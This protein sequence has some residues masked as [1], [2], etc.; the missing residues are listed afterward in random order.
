MINDCFYFVLSRIRGLCEANKK[1]F[2]D[3]IFYPIGNG[4]YWS[5]FRK[6][7]FYPAM[8]QTERS[9]SVSEHECY[10]YRRNRWTYKSVMLSELGRQLVG[11]IMKAMEVNL[12]KAVKFKYKL[13]ANPDMLDIETQKEF[14][15]MGISLP[16]VIRDSVAEYYVQ[17]TRKEVLV[18]PENLEKIRKEALNIQ[19]KLIV[20]ED[21]EETS[22]V[23][24]EVI[25]AVQSVSDVWEKFRAALS[26]T[27]LDAL[28]IVLQERS[29][30]TFASEN[31]IM[32]EVLIDGINQKAVDCIG[33]TVMEFDGSVT[34][35]DDYR[36]KLTDMANED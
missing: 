3:F 29:I 23:A 8:K 32:P 33:D 12:R 36:E 24:A 10:T 34:V 25:A 11:Y 30:K 4:A 2:E 28:E 5:P 14:D 31:G 7:L 35:Y 13:T 15:A 20:P 26:K 1:L 6:A 21:T 18:N 9:V 17:S 27:E 19:D 16:D 22:P